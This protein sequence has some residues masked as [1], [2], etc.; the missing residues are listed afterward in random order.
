[1]VSSNTLLMCD[2]GQM[3]LDRLSLF[4]IDPMQTALST[5]RH[6]RSHF[7]NIICV[8]LYDSQADDDMKRGIK[9]TQKKYQVYYIHRS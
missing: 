3:R 2:T 7:I 5:M 4:S 1:M 8:P 6:H 9:E